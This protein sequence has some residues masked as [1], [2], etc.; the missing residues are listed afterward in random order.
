[1]EVAMTASLIALCAMATWF[2]V[3]EH[4]VPNALT[5]GGFVVAL[6]L[7]ALQSGLPGL[8][9]GL[10]GALVAFAIALPFFMVG[11][12]GGGDVK[13]LTAVGAFL[14]LGSVLPFLAATAIVGG[15]MAL[16]L[17]LF[18]RGLFRQTLA[19]LHTMFLTLGRKTF[20]GWKSGEAN[21][22]LLTLD[23]PGAVTLPYAVAI[24][25]GALLAWFVL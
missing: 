8:G 16:V 4:R 12:L 7:Q 2:D 25:A 3:R 14:G 15:V 21:Q 11:G 10:G 20:T 23:S 6:A 24:A 17:M 5:I 13:L 1:M 22:A 19:N 9:T 18:R